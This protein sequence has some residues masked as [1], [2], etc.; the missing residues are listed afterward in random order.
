MVKA[1]DQN[2]SARSFRILREAEDGDCGLITI[3]VKYSHGQLKVPKGR[4][5][6]SVKNCA[7]SCHVF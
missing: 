6:V 4:D 1:V 5:E 3:A 2:K 7:I